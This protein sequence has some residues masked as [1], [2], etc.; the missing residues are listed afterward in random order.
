MRGRVY[1]V[2]GCAALALLAA[3]IA[4]AQLEKGSQAPDF[5][6]TGLDGREFGLKPLISE[7]KAQKAVVVLAFWATWC[8]PCRAEA[9]HLQ[10]ISKDYADRGVAVVGVSLDG[11]RSS[12]VQRFVDQQKLTYTVVLDPDGKAANKYRVRSIPTLF[13]I[14]S[15][16]VIRATRV[17]YGPGSEKELAKDIDRILAAK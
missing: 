14:D 13:V 17:G 12:R 8:P 9:P 5:K 1:A 7:G 3:G 10:K 4:I 15:G 11:P 6:A 16:G 2:A